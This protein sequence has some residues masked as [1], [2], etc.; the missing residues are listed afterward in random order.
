[1]KSSDDAKNT[2][3]RFKKA[4]MLNQ[5]WTGPFHSWDGSSSSKKEAQG[6][7]PDSWDWNKAAV[8]E[9]VSME[10]QACQRHQALNIPRTGFS[11]VRLPY[12][13]ALPGA[14]CPYNQ[15]NED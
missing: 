14:W 2:Q 6:P 1:M 9:E 15:I 5:E 8:V 3:Q 4:L 11:K 10:T 13:L 7:Q 12:V